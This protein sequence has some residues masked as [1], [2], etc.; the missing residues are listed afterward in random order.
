VPNP[1]LLLKPISAVGRALGLQRWL[2]V[3]NE[4]LGIVRNRHTLGRQYLRGSGIEIG[5]LAHPLLVAEDVHVTYLDHLTREECIRRFPELDP[6]ALV[7]PEIIDDGFTL[8]AVAAGSQDFLIAN[9]V[10]E[11]APN[12]Y[13]V[14]HAW[15]RV[16]R[17]HGILFVAVPDVGQCFD[18]GRPAT[19]ARHLLEDYEAGLAVDGAELHR[20]CLEHYLEWMTV[21]HD[22]CRAFLGQEP[23]HLAP[24]IARERAL[25]LWRA[26]SDIHFHTFSPSSFREDLELFCRRLM[27]AMG[28]F[29]YYPVKDEIVALLRKRDS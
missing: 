22:P 23:E 13:A 12:P 8:A 26:R 19:P 6:A 21:S 29:R 2:R 7:T 28:L 17:P 15:C 25:Q 20:R 14:L 3:A 1:E 27:P 16:L 18:R 4:R 24:E 5:A 10:L 11:H 9:H